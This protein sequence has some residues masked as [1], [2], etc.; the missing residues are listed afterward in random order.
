MT[1]TK[2]KHFFSVHFFAKKFEYKPDGKITEYHLKLSHLK[3][4]KYLILL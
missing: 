3:S 2:V 4:D 1:L